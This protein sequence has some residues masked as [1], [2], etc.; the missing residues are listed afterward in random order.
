MTGALWK[1]TLRE[2]WNTKGRFLSILAIIGLGVGFFASVKGTSPCMVATAEQYY[3]QYNL[4]DLRL[5]SSVGFDDDDIK[6]IENADGVS[7]VQSGYV[8][9]IIIDNNNKAQVYRLH[10]LNKDDNAINRLD[11]IEGRL[12]EKSGEIV[13]ENTIVKNLNIGDKVKIENKAGDAD[14]SS[15]LKKLEYTIVGFVNSPMYI[16]NDRGTSNIGSGDI[17]GFGYILPE[18]YAYE[19]YTEVYVTSK[20]TQEGVSPFSDEYKNCID[21]ITEN[22][23]KIGEHRTEVFTKE[24]VDPAKKE[25]EE[26]QKKYKEEKKQ[27]EQ[28]LNDAEKKLKEGEKTLRE[29]TE[30][31]QQ[32]LDEAEKQLQEGETVLPYSITSFYEEIMLAQQKIND[33]KLQL[34]Q[35]KSDLAI[36]KNSYET[37]VAAAQLQL[38]NA[39][40]EYDKAYKEFYEVTK[41]EA[42]AKIKTYSK[43]IEEAKSAIDK[44]EKSGIP[45]TDGVKE[46]LNKLKASLSEYETQLQGGYTRLAEGEQQLKDAKAQ[47]DRGVTELEAQKRTGQEQINIAQSKIDE[48]QRQIDEGQQDLDE[49]TRNGREELNNARSQITQGKVSLEEGKLKLETEKTDGEN[50]LKSGQ[51]ELEAQ[52]KT[53]EEELKKAKE[54]LNDAENQLEALSSPQWH[55]MKRND[56]EGYKSFSSTTESMDAIASIFPL[57]FLIVAVLVCLTTMTRLLEERRTEIGTLKA[58]GYS[59]ASITFKYIIYAV[60]AGLIGCVIGTAITVPTIPNVIFNAYRI[61]YK[62]PPLVMKIPW[63][64]IFEGVGAAVICSVGIVLFVCRKSLGKMPA[65]LMRPKAPKPGKRILLERI[66]PLWNHL[67]FTSKVTA[68]NLFR[69]KTRLLMTVLGVAGCTAL[70]VAA[71]GIKNS[72]NTVIDKQFTDI[73]KISGM[74]VPSSAG[75]AED[76]EE[77]CSF[78]K[79]YDNVKDVL[80]IDYQQCTVEVNGEDESISVYTPGNVSA[81]T[82]MIDLHTRQSNESVP[83]TNSGVVITEKLGKI[84]GLGEGDVIT[85]KYGDKEYKA[86]ITGVCENYVGHYIYMTPDYYKDIYGSEPKFNLIAEMS[87][88]MTSDNEEEFA[89]VL[90]QRDDVLTVSFISSSIESVKNIMDNINIIVYVMILFAAILAF[91]VLYNLTNINIAE[92]KREIATIKVLGF[93]NREV[94]EYIYR[95]NIILTVLGILAG[96][97]MGVFLN[98]FIIETAEVSDIMFG[99]DAGLMS[100]IYAIGLTALFALIVNFFMYFKM[101]IISM[102]ESLKS[103]E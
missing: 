20:Y 18:D 28:K 33:S 5:I 11:V 49:A 78:I 39:Q 40:S 71:F 54:K 84:T 19:R 76:L 82:K 8:A 99:R 47:L 37:Q 93:Y 103:I 101:K 74:I 88:E 58:L 44:I 95:E 16:S 69:Y 55:I 100:F 79:E 38:D 80:P 34:A 42:E 89:N 30:K 52:K 3:S 64:Y 4:M 70:I 90:L 65:K 56:Y 17:A 61:M 9:D 43:L 51:K 73:S 23:E 48:A 24:I 14:T 59:S 85:Y 35:G 25:L 72:I 94:G 91:V 10:S 81:M 21:E 67:S 66:K 75:N 7:K 41:P 50:K 29:E 32:A 53:A 15:M 45:L 63:I 2:I 27:A 22:I 60:T 36:A 96:L 31:A 12:P 46:N 6:A 26:G 57:F 83:L 1:N 77:L 97:V 68:R 62:M 86:K 87:E 98:S 92:R 102:V 13:L